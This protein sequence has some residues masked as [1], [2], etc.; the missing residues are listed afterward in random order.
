MRTA[1]SLALAAAALWASAAPASAQ[2]LDTELVGQFSSPIYATSPAGDLDR[3]FVVQQG[4]LIRI[5]ENPRTAP[6]ILATPFL[7]LTTLTNG[8]G[9]RGLLGLAFHPDYAN[10]GRFFVNFTNNAGNTRVWEYGVSAD[11]NVADPNMVQTILVASQPFSNH[12]GGCLQFGPDGMLYIGLGDGGSGNDPGNRS[13]DPMNKLGKMIRLDIDLASPFIPS[14]NPFVGDPTTLDEIWH[15]GLRNP[16][17]YSFDSLTGDLWCAD[18]GQNAREEINFQPASSTGGE[19]YGWRCM[20]GFSCTGLSGCTCNGASLTLPIDDYTHGGGRCSITGGYVYRG[21]QI[22]GLDGTYF[23]GDFC[24]RDVWA[25]RYDGTTVTQNLNVTADLQPS[26]GGTIGNI[27][28][29][30]QDGAG[31]LYIVTSTGGR[32]WRITGDCTPTNSNYCVAGANS[33]GAG[34]AQISSLGSLALSDNDFTLVV[35]D[36]PTNQF[37]LF[38]Y[39]GGTANTP[40]GDGF[41]CVGAPLFRLLPPITTGSLGVASRQVDFT[42]LPASS[43]PGQIVSGSSYYFQFWYRDITPGGFNF[44]NGLEAV[45]CP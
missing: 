31:E 21:S 27:T 40:L 19:N 5:V 45:F 37:G 22:P 38:F 23:Y 14:D 18:V 28:S 42:V 7:D 17:R 4:G 39:G 2:S 12:N 29:F 35:N 11:P 6:N 3:L 24:S 16:W 30:G 10:N 8:G 1:T 36:A 25:L 32:I 20:E 34:G 33:A 43:G 15:I 13:Q 44:S 9:E 41:L 26:A